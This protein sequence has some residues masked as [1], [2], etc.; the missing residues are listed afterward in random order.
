MTH[1]LQDS[2]VAA[3]TAVHGFQR[4]QHAFFAQVKMQAAELPFM[5]PWLSYLVFQKKCLTGHAMWGVPDICQ[6]ATA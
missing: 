6:Q 4:G 5:R 1:A 3:A 2:P